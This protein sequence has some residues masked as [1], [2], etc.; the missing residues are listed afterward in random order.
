MQNK[1]VQ[2]TPK[3]N[4]TMIEGVHF[5]P[6]TPDDILRDQTVRDLLDAATPL[7]DSI[8]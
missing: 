6:A 7:T 5:V 3:Q 2:E 4:H 1:P 8:Q